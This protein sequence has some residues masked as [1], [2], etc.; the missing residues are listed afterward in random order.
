MR[1]AV[2]HLPMLPSADQRC[3]RCNRPWWNPFGFGSQTASDEP[4]ADLFTEV[5]VGP[6]GTW[7]ISKP[8]MFSVES[9]LA[10]EWE[11]FD[12]GW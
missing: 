7:E 1:E 6:N 8:R 4:F 2:K 10:S 11:P 12:A 3:R 9:I 5:R